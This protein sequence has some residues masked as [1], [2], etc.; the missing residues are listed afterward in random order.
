MM[1]LPS[2]LPDDPHYEPHRLLDIIASLALR[3][4]A[5]LSRARWTTAPLLN[6]VRHRRQAVES[7][8][9]IR[10]HGA[11]TPSIPGI[12]DLPRD[13]RHRA[14]LLPLMEALQPACRHA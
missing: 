5:T 6:K 7:E 10:I 2:K 9:M 12:R 4:D 14:Q 3:N 1:K 13:S 11:T 8:L